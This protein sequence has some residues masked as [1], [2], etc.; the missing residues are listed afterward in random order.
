MSGFIAIA[1][2]IAGSLA[3]AH[4]DSHGGGTEK[5][6]APSQAP[7]RVAALKLGIIE[8]QIIQTIL[9]GEK[10]P[11]DVLLVHCN[12]TESVPCRGLTIS[13]SN[14]R[15][16]K[17]L[18][19]HSGGD[20]WVGFQGLNPIES[21]EIKVEGSKYEAV[22]VTGSGTIRRILAKRSNNKEN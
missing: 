18:I 22:E 2:L 20:G 3:H 17:L 19:G 4:G 1:I 9:D 15:G 16:E 5:K 10:V 7:S 21:Y 6:H 11:S 12:I 8:S 14:L 13:L